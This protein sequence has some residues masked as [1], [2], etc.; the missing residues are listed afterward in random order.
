MLLHMLP[1]SWV[2]VSISFRD[3]ADIDISYTLV[4]IGLFGAYCS[5]LQMACVIFSLSSMSR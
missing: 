5:V 2:F 1:R 3:S 4:Y